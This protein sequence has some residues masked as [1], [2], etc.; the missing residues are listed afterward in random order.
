MEQ[1]KVRGLV[2]LV[3]GFLV[4]F[5]SCTNSHT[6][7]QPEVS[8]SSGSNPEITD[9]TVHENRFLPTGKEKV[10][11]SDSLP[12]FDSCSTIKQLYPLSQFIVYGVV[13]QVDYWGENGRGNT[14]YDFIIKQT[15]KGN[16]EKND[17][18]SVMTAGGYCKLESYIAV[19]GKD[20][21]EEMADD[22]IKNTVIQE[23]F[24]GAPTPEKGDVYV[25]F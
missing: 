17:K 6:P 13:D 5:C 2:P 23:S 14:V 10:I 3:L 8:Q 18:I 7:S 19:S 21:F 11:P 15:Y 24:Y 1:S 20:R 9:K 4:F 12:Q 22:E 25:L 16:L